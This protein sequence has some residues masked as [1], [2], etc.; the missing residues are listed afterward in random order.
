MGN[1]FLRIGR[2]SLHAFLPVIASLNR[3]RVTGERF[4]ARPPVSDAGETRALTSSST[5]PT[6]TEGEGEGDGEGDMEKSTC[7]Q[8]QHSDWK[9]AV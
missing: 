5:R 1:R 2:R 4:P 9:S 8:P 3:Q 6:K 7:L